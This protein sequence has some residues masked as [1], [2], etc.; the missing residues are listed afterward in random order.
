MEYGQSKRFL[1][2][3]ADWEAGSPAN[4]DLRDIVTA[5]GNYEPIRNLGFESW[6]PTIEGYKDSV[7][8]GLELNFSDLERIEPHRVGEVQFHSDRYRILVALYRRIPGLESK[9]PARER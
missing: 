7:S 3:L 6:Y 8:V 5:R 1:D 9:I 2:S 4:L